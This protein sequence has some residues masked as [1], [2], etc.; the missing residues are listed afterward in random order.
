[1]TG[2]FERRE[3]TNLIG[4]GD[5]SSWFQLHIDMNAIS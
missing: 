3:S 4:K 1:M 5:S 2:A